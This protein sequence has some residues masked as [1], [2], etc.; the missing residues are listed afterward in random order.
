LTGGIIRSILLNPGNYASLISVLS[1]AVV[2]SCGRTD[3]QTDV[4]KMFTPKFWLN[5]NPR[6]LHALE[7]L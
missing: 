3:G 2:F 7:S 5:V 1:G 4:A 6:F